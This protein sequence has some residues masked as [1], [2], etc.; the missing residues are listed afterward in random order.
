MPRFHRVILM[1][2]IDSI[3]RPHTIK[4]PRVSVSRVCIG[5]AYSGRWHHHHHHYQHHCGTAHLGPAKFDVATNS[6]RKKAM[7][8]IK[9]GLYYDYRLWWCVLFGHFSP[10]LMIVLAIPEIYTS[11]VS[12]LIFRLINTF[13]SIGLTMT[14]ISHIKNNGTFLSV[15]L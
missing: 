12:I 3:I 10:L 2:M 1:M 9:H 15:T 11:Q 7:F 14:H 5:P 13:G 8:G 4:Y 6:E